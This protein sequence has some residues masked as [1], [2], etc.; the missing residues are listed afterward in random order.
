MKTS[1]IPKLNTLDCLLPSSLLAKEMHKE[2]SI[3]IYHTLAKVPYA[4]ASCR[5]EIVN[6]DNSRGNRII[7]RYH[8]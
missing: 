6:F 1:F 8:K 2:N 4:R 5:Q 3:R 7:T